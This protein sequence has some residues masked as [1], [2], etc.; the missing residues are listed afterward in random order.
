MK[1]ILSR[2]STIFF[3]WSVFQ[4]LRL[5][6]CVQKQKWGWISILG[7]NAAKLKQV[8]KKLRKLSLKL[9]CQ[10]ICEMESN[11]G[12]DQEHKAFKTF[13]FLPTAFLYSIPWPSHLLNLINNFLQT[14]F[15]PH[16]PSYFL[17]FYSLLDGALWTFEP[18][19]FPRTEP[20]F[21]PRTDWANICKGY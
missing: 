12:G 3:E 13:K 17:M 9:A 8:A 10:R 14:T 16:K 20:M 11:I 5:K 2:E 6:N 7:W 18:W 1:A 15:L 21:E 19:P 4:L